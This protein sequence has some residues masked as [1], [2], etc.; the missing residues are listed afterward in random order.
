MLIDTFLKSVRSQ[1]A[2]A[3]L[4]LVAEEQVEAPGVIAFRKLD[5]KGLAD[6]YR[7]AWIFSLPS[8]Y[9][10]FGLPY[11]EAMASGTAIVGTFNVGLQELSRGGSDAVIVS[12]ARYG[13]ALVEMLRDDE[14]RDELGDRGRVRAHEFGWDCVVSQHLQLYR[15]VAG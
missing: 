9:E 4:W 11:L 6:L 12:D 1:I 2:N 3:H 15:E 13:D 10:G 7:Q 8:T 14:K 5:E